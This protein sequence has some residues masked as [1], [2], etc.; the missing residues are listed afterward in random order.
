[1]KGPKNPLWLWRCRCRPHVYFV[2]HKITLLEVGV[3]FFWKKYIS[4]NILR[5][6]S[7]APPP[8]TQT[9][10]NKQKNK[11]KSV[12]QVFFFTLAE[13]LVMEQ[14]IGTKW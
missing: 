9:K 14:L 10:Q 6:I 3:Y 2:Y 12:I 4:W 13:N 1:M 7:E 11:K 5:F 8:K